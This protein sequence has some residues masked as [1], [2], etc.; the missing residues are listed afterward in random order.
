KRLQRLRQSPLLRSLT[1]ENAPRAGQLIQPL[2]AVEG[3]TKDEEIPGL[4]NNLRLG[5]ES[6]RRQVAQDLEAGG[7]QFLLF[8]VPAEKR[9]R[10]F[11]VELTQTAIADLNRDF[12]K[13][14]CLWTDTCLCSFTS[15]GHCCV[16]DEEGGTDLPETLNALAS[17]ALSY[18]EAGADGI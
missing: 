6:L 12:G 8:G 7:T 1:A 4:R 17:L 16:F 3:L 11:Q 10:N 14:L 18:A 13:D 5:R 15:H 2:F 9:D